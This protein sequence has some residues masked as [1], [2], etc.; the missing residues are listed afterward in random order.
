MK[1]FFIIISLCLANIVKAQDGYLKIDTVKHEESFSFPVIISGDSIARNKINVH[2][3]LSELEHIADKNDVSMF[4]KI[5]VEG[6]GYHPIKDYVLAKIVANTSRCFSVKLDESG[7]G[8]MTTHYWN[9]YYNFNPQNG[10]RY[11]LPDFFDAANYQKFRAIVTK[12]RQEKLAS[13]V[14]EHLKADPSD[15]NMRYMENYIYDAIAKDDYDDFYFDEEAIY[16]DNENLLTWNDKYYDLDQETGVDIETIKP[17]LNDY[18]MSVLVTGE[19]LKA[20][21][22]ITEPQLYEGAIDRYAIYLLFTHSD[23][24]GCYGSYAYKKQ[25]TGIN[26]YGDFKDGTYILSEQDEDYNQVAVLTFK[27]DKNT[28]AG[29]W[30]GKEKG[31]TL[32][33]RAIRK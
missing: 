7:S 29:N 2:L 13:Q 26:L 14:Q 12:A 20:Y 1:N 9:R 24:G 10:D 22:G 33:F 18:G 4:S 28:L 8:I 11:F 15:S 19:N 6:E 17:L 32:P 27:K 16:F 31:N 5:T 30:K 25:R 23:G 21:R 3:Q